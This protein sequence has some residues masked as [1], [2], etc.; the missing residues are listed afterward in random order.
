MDDKE[1][2]HYKDLL[3]GDSRQQQPEAIS[4]LDALATVVLPEKISNLINY[5]N[6]AILTE[7]KQNNICQDPD[8]DS[9]YIKIVIKDFVDD[10]TVT[11]FIYIAELYRSRGWY[12]IE[13]HHNHET[14]E[15]QFCFYF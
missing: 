4:V 13:I 7:L 11:E 3:F 15:L 6:D 2:Y 1:A 8:T 14:K 12:L 9:R 5:F 10:H